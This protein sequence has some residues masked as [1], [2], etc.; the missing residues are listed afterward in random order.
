M[1]IAINCLFAPS[2]Q[3]LAAGTIDFLDTVFHDR[4]LS[5]YAEGNLGQAGG[6]PLA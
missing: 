5:H 3:P 2:N 1:Y 6:S 4:I